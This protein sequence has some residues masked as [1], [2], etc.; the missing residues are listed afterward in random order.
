MTVALSVTTLPEVAV[1][2][3][4]PETLTVR[5]AEVVVRDCPHSRPGAARSRQLRNHKRPRRL[6]PVATYPSQRKDKRK[7]ERWPD[8][9]C[10]RKSRPGNTGKRGERKVMKSPTI[11]AGA[12]NCW[13]QRPWNAIRHS[14]AHRQRDPGFLEVEEG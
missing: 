11:K 5:V 3:A 7:R 13:S 10:L 6:V 1:L 4:E 14:L 9:N 8:K 12:E 2:A